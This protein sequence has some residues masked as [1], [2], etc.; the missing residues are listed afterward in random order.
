ML[1]SLVTDWARPRHLVLALLAYVPLAAVMFGPW[2]ELLDQVTRHCG[3]LR[4][5]DVRGSWTADDARTMLGVCGNSG[6]TAYVQMEIADLAYPAAVGAALLVTTAL[7][8]RRFGGRTWPL[9][10]PA[11]LMTLLDYTENAGIWTLLL[12][13]PHLNATVADAA[14]NATMAKRV[15]GFIAFSTPAVLAAV[16]LIHRGRLFVAHHRAAPAP[17]RMLRPP[18]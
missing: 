13:W 9:L 8:L 17:A 1:R 15:L 4:P 2:P 14:G 12:Q 6:R 18:R 7:L 16:A 5:F 10:L 11:A 3:G